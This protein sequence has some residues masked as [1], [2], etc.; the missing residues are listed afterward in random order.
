MSKGKKTAKNS[1]WKK[2]DRGARLPRR[3]FVKPRLRTRPKRR[4]KKKNGKEKKVRPNFIL[5][6]YVIG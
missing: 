4:P 5:R 1:N 6:L 2:S 3:L